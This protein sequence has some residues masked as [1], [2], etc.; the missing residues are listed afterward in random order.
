[1]QPNHSTVKANN[2]QRFK[3]SGNTFL[4]DLGKGTFIQMFVELPEAATLTAN[5]FIGT[6]TLVGGFAT[7]VIEDHDRVFPTRSQAGVALSGLP[8]MP[9]ACS[10]QVGPERII[11]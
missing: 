7:S 3:L 5:W 10:G 9:S 1:V 2:V 8:A 4:N 11:D 6:A